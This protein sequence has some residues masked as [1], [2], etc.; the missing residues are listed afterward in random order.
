MRCEGG[1]WLVGSRG[2]A[3]AGG[4]REGTRRPGPWEG[5][6][7]LPTPHTVDAV[8]DSEAPPTGKGAVAQR[9]GSLGRRAEDS[10]VWG[11]RGQGLDS[12]VS[13]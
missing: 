11:W 3:R 6:V 13:P 2:R 8:A 9:P 5:A 4:G 12:W 1:V 10:R 7:F